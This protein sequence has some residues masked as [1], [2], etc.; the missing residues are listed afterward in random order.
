MNIAIFIILLVLS[1]IIF[2]YI[3]PTIKTNWIIF[4]TIKRGIVYGNCNWWKLSDLFTDLTGV[5]IYY[6]LKRK[7]GAFIPMN[8]MGTRHYIVT[9]I[10]AIKEILDNSPDTF[11]VG[12][13]KCNFFKSFMSKNVGVSGGIGWKERRI[14]NEF[15]LDSSQSIITSIDLSS[16]LNSNT[17]TFQDFSNY[18]RVFTMK[19]VFGVDINDPNY[20]GPNDV[21]FNMLRD[22]NSLRVLYSKSKIIDKKLFNDYFNSLNKFVENPVE[23]SLIELAVNKIKNDYT[24]DPTTVALDHQIPHW[25]FPFN[26]IITNMIPRLILLLYQHPKIL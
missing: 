3:Y 22:A 6:Y 15:V 14:L 12:K 26:G 24:L 20:I 17:L 1:A 9:D 8:I 16:F 10:T 7:Y 11:G 21:F 18:A 23:N 13:M 5:N 2:N 25:I 19:V 4:L